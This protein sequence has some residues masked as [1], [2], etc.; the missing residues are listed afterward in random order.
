M[1][2][3]AGETG[4]GRKAAALSRRAQAPW[5]YLAGAAEH[6]TRRGP[7]VEGRCTAIIFSDSGFAI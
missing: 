6:V 4:Q 3:V 2:W 5:G 1:R 7:L